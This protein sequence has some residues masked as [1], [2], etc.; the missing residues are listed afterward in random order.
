MLSVNMGITNVL[1]TRQIEAVASPSIDRLIMFE[2]KVH[3]PNKK[4]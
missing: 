2:L 4:D 3:V 1:N